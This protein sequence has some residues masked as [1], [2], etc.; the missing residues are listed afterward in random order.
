MEN[1]STAPTVEIVN[2]L[3]T[4]DSDARTREFIE[5]LE[6]ML[7]GGEFSYISAD[8][9]RFDAVFMMVIKELPQ[10]HHDH[11]EAMWA[12]LYDP[13]VTTT[14]NEDHMQLRLQYEAGKRIRFV[15]FVGDVK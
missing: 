2:A 3:E 1:Q 14:N 9:S 10:Q 7:G 11:L 15:A 13:L 4:L 12:S 6:A 8:Y 5:T